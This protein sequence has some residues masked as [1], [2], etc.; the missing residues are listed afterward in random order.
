MLQTA[1]TTPAS[2]PA[3]MGIITDL[4]AYFEMMGCNKAR[5]ALWRFACQMITRGGLRK[6]NPT[7]R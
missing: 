6:C 1:R 5:T 2:E 3:P 4:C 7:L